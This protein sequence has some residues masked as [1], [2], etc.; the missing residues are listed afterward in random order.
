MADLIG[1]DLNIYK[2]R[3]AKQKKYCLHCGRELVSWQTKF[4]SSSCSATYNNLKR[5]PMPEES[6]K[7]ISEKLKNYYNIPINRI[8]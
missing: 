6:K 1:F 2:E 3:Q 8:N 7:L 4:C 5:C